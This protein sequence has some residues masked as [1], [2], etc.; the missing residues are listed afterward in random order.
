TEVQAMDANN[1]TLQWSVDYTGDFVPGYASVIGNT[2]VLP[3]LGLTFIDLENGTERNGDIKSRM[4]GARNVTK[5][6]DGLMALDN[7]L[8][9]DFGKVE[10]SGDCDRLVPGSVHFDDSGKL[11]YFTTYNRRGKT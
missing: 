10:T 7:A 4:E 8:V 11:C 2:L 9:G 6:L 5:G 1:G 3:F